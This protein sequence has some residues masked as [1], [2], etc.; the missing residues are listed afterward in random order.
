MG[1]PASESLI[2]TLARP[3]AVKLA[4]RVVDDGF[5]R[6]EV[7]DRHAVPPAH[8]NQV[9]LVR[10]LKP[11]LWFLSRACQEHACP[12][13]RRAGALLERAGLRRVRFHDLR[14]STATLLLACGVHP[15][16]VSEILGHSRISITLDLYTHV[17]EDMQ[18]EAVDRLQDLLGSQRGSQT[19]EQDGNKGDAA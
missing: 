5:G 16:I 11:P 7:F 3:G 1:V 14:H 9:N 18:R 12:E 10:R 15:K 6:V 4:V 19:P 8:S 13:F 2:G 17:S